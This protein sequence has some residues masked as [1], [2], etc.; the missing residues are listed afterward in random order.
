MMLTGHKKSLRMFVKVSIFLK[1]YFFCSIVFSQSLSCNLFLAQKHVLPPHAIRILNTA[2]VLV[3]ALFCCF[4]LIYIYCCYFCFGVLFC[5][6]IGK[7]NFITCLCGFF[8]C[9]FVRVCMCRWVNVCENV[10]V[11]VCLC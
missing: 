10:W 11:P 6:F 5:R 8:L 9:V 3:V 2:S 7:F 1:I 4:N